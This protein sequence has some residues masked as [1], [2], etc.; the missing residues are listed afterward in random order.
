[1]KKQ[2]QKMISLGLSVFLSVVPSVVTAADLQPL[3]S[4]VPGDINGDSFV[5]IADAM[6]LFQH[7]MLPEQFPVAYEGNLDLNKDGMV[8][9]ADAILLF[10]HSMLPDL[11]P[12]DWGKQGE[13]FSM[14]DPKKVFDAAELPLSFDSSILCASS[15]DAKGEGAEVS[16]SAW[17][18]TADVDLNGCYGLYYNLSA[19]K[20]LMSV[21]FYDAEGHYISGVG[22]N[23]MNSYATSVTGFAVRPENAVTA[24]FLYFEGTYV[25]PRFKY[26]TV[27]SFADKEAYDE[28]RALYRF[29]GLKIACLGDSLTEGDYG[30]MNGRQGG[31]RF[32]NYPYYLGQLTGATTV[33]FGRCGASSTSYL[34]EHYNVGDID[35][36]EFDVILLMLGTNKGLAMDSQYYTDY[37]TLVDKILAEKKPEA[38]L[39]LIT[40]PSATTN[41]LKTNY[42]YMDNVTSANA[43]VLAIAKE[44]GLV[45]FDALKMSPIQPDKENLYQSYDGLHLNARGYEAFAGY[46]AK[47][48]S[49]ILD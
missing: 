44:K 16:Y 33:N 31:R 11:F 27:L 29:D 40:P 10:Q 13:D 46:I 39:I 42:G 24:R 12:I 25:I 48:L 30:P 9:I 5:D 49:K 6:A 35:V 28:A 38:Q 21:A 41:P 15:L 20:L 14:I 18:G 1:M 45:C 43:A 17:W 23:S 32:E 8:D 7:S 34:E 22:T 37:C 3:S 26:S 36:S 4:S 2:Y 47:E 19:H